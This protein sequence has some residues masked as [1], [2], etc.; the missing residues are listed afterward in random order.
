MTITVDNSQ[1]FWTKLQRRRGLLILIG[2]S[3]SLL[4]DWTVSHHS[5]IRVLC[6]FFDP[7]AVP[8]ISNALCV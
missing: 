4:G 8:L 2:T 1:D 3:S 6:P 5:Y 7:E